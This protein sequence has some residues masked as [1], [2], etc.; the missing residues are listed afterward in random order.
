[1]ITRTL[2]GEECKSV[3]FHYVVFSTPLLLVSSLTSENWM[4]DKYTYDY[5]Q[6]NG[7]SKNRILCLVLCT[8]SK[9]TKSVSS[10]L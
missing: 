6:I 5:I 9:S 1:L 10:F 8:G 7:D 4:T 2:V 3:S